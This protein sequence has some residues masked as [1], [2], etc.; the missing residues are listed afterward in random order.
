MLPFAKSLY[1]NANA[2]KLTQILFV[3]DTNNFY[4]RRYSPAENASRFGQSMLIKDKNSFYSKTKPPGGFS[5]LAGALV[6]S[7]SSGGGGGS[8]R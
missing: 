3:G 2:E 8:T 4:G 6:G 7:G 1:T 5:A